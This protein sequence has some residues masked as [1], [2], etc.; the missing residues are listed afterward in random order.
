MCLL[1]FAC[2]LCRCAAGLAGEELLLP[3]SM[4]HTPHSLSCD[5]VVKQHVLKVLVLYVDDQQLQERRGV[6]HTSTQQQASGKEGGG[7][8]P[9]HISMSCSQTGP[10]PEG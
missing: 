5:A 4:S 8:G 6:V 10:A 3:A 7:G 9:A 2:L 1:A